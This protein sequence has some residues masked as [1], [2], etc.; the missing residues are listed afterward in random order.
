MCILCLLPY[1][2]C[3]IVVTWWGGPGGIEAWFFGPLLPSVLWHYLLCHL[4]HKNAVPDK[5]YSVF[6][7][8]VYRYRLTL[9]NQ[10]IKVVSLLTCSTCLPS[11]LILT[12]RFPW[13]EI[14][15]IF[16]ALVLIFIWY[17]FDRN[18]MLVNTTKTKEMILGPLA[19]SDLSILSTRVGTVGR[20][21]SFKFLAVYIEST[22]SWSLHIDNM[23]KKA[24]QRL[25]FLNN[26]KEQVYQV[27]I[28]SLLQHSYTPRTWVLCCSVTLRPD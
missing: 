1:V 6:S 9:L 10:S 26:L 13:R 4:T 15:M 5:T 21:S 7:G 8:T 2:I 28:F 23:V 27:S 14:R 3:C 18:D 16:V 25:Y 12:L 17:S 20:V 19:R 11:I 24:T 22:L